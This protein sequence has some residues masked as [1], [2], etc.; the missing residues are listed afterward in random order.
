[1]EALY[2]CSYD[3]LIFI[4]LVPQSLRGIEKGITLAPPDG[5]QWQYSET[6]PDELPE[7]RDEVY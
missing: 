7:E 5:S 6:D 1:M 2:K 3:V 4:I